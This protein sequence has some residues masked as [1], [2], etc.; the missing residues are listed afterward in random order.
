MKKSLDSRMSLIEPIVA[1]VMVLLLG[2]TMLFGSPIA[3]PG[4]AKAASPK[5]DI[6]FL[7][8]CNQTQSCTNNTNTNQE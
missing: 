3:L 8:S 5:P 2:S 1:T 6:M 7:L 4:L